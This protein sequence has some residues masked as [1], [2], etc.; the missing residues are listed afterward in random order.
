MLAATATSASTCMLNSML[1]VF[2]ATELGMSAAQYAGAVLTLQHVISLAALALVGTVN[3]MY[4]STSV[5]ATSMAVQG[6]LLLVLGAVPSYSVL[7]LTAPLASTAACIC[8]VQQN[9][10]IQRAGQGQPDAY[11]AHLNATY[12]VLQAIV[13]VVMP[14][15]LTNV[16]LPNVPDSGFAWTFQAVGAMSLLLSGVVAR[17]SPAK[18]DVVGCPPPKTRNWPWAQKNLLWFD[19]E[20]KSTVVGVLAMAN[21]S[22]TIGAFMATR[23]VKELQGS[24]ASYGLLQSASALLAICAM[25]GT[26]RL[27]GNWPARRVYAIIQ[28][29]MGTVRMLLVLTDSLGVTMLLFLV[30]SVLAKASAV[31]HSMTIADSCRHRPGLELSSVF[32]LEK[33]WVF[34]FPSF[35]LIFLFLVFLY[36]FSSFLFNFFVSLFLSPLFFHL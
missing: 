35:L 4:T 14:F 18:V 21:P 34:A 3:R 2:A 32:A 28:L 33:V 24:S 31:S 13:A 19:P 15:V 11:C 12:R 9:S 5:L 27:F 10:M 26:A 17:G 29:V 23:I 22:I 20:M 6:V 36:F 1:P 30:H 16:V 7:L 25:M 8:L